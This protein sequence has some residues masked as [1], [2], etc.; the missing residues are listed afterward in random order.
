MFARFGHFAANYGAERMLGRRLYLDHLGLT[1][2][3][4]AGTLGGPPWRSGPPRITIPQACFC[5]DQQLTALPAVR[6]A[7]GSEAGLRAFMR[8]LRSNAAFWLLLQEAAEEAERRIKQLPPELRRFAK[9]DLAELSAMASW[10]L[11]ECKAGRAVGGSSDSDSSGG[12]GSDSRSGSA[13]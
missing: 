11:R 4:V 7:G 13:T 12:G 2:Q 9:V 10:Q 8:G 1:G 3:V 6:Q 5:T